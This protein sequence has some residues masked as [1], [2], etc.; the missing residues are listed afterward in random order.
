[1]QFSIELASLQFSLT[2]MEQSEKVHGTMSST[3]EKHLQQCK[4]S[5]KTIED[6]TCFMLSNIN[7]CLD[8][9]KA[10]SGLAL[11]ASNS[12][13]DLREALQW[14]VNCIQR[15]KEKH[16]IHLEKISN[17]ILIGR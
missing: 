14:A 2:S 3:G 8:Y 13:F 9:T 17:D 7:R 12:T 6:I 4:E 5:I 10:S 16:N 11:A 15:S 1:M